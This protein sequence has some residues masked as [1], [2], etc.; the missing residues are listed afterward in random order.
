VLRDF[1]VLKKLNIHYAEDINSGGDCQ[2]QFHL[3]SRQ[4]KNFAYPKTHAPRTSRIFERLNS[5]AGKVLASKFYT[6]AYSKV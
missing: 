4:S 2:V 6:F 3:V 5:L 1:C